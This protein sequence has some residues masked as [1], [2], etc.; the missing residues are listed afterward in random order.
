VPGSITV[1][2]ERRARLDGHVDAAMLAELVAQA[3]QR[4]DRIAT[5][6]PVTPGLRKTRFSTF[7]LADI[8]T[9]FNA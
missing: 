1:N 5:R 8:G 6:H 4:F 9:G 3:R 2:V 7:F